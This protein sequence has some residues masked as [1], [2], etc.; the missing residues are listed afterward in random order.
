MLT[1]LDFLNAGAPWPPK[2][3]RARIK[4]YHDNKLLF[5]GDHYQVFKEIWMRLFRAEWQISVEMMLNWP[6][7]LSTLWA[8]LLLGETPTLTDGLNADAGTPYLEELSSRVKLWNAAYMAALD[9]SRYGDAV[10]K[11]RRLADG[12]VRL[13]IIP[14]AFWF[15][16]ISETDAKEITAQVIAWP[17]KIDNENPF[18]K[19]GQLHVEIHTAERIEYRT[20]KL[21]APGGT[22][23]DAIEL[24]N[25]V[26]TVGRALIVHCPGLETSDTIYGMDD[27]DNLTSLM[28]E[29]EVRFAQTAKILDR[30]AEPK[31]YGPASVLTRDEKSGRVKADVGDYFP[32][33]T[34]D[35]VAPAYLV[36]NA[37]LE[38]SFTEIDSL[39]QQF[40]M[41][42]ETSPAV[43]G[44][45]ENGLAES[46]SALKRLFMAPLAKVNRVRMN[47]DPALKEVLTVLSVLDGK[48]ADEVKP[49]IHW[50]DGL[51]DDEGEQVTTASTAVAC[52]I[53]S[54]RSAMKRAFGY[55]DSQ[56]DEEM[57]QID[58]EKETVVEPDLNL[59]Q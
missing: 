1:N 30:H 33:D 57:Q 42:S 7:R 16:V 38:N 8:D 47:F 37:Q 53:S 5:E 17:S 9:T 41:L 46:G 35:D 40:Y 24:S 54:K 56:A 25:E 39:M 44:K 13:S 14:P 22:L 6:K 21:P 58:D 27:Y 26:N 28:Q 51:P 48:S 43:F 50:K 12:Q 19:D 29:L 10:F 59:N 11:M 23:G 34:T 3:E 2:C 49:V 52:G 32:L 36:W 55:N 15:P 45:I 18:N 31:M 4:R 20:Y